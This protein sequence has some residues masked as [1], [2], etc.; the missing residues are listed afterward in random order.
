MIN[1]P[2]ITIDGPSGSG[3]GT[4]AIAV[5]DMLGWHV[6]DSGALY[7]IV[8]YSAL[9]Q[10]LSFDDP[11]K[12]SAMVSDLVIDFK[13]PDPT[14]EIYV[15]GQ[16]VTRDLRTDRVSK[17]ASVAAQYE[18][19]RSSLL[20]LQRKFRRPPG[21]VADGR[22]MGTVVFADAPLKIYLD[23]SVEVRAARRYKQLKEKGLNGTFRGLSDVKLACTK[24]DL[25]GV[26]VSDM[27]MSEIDANQNINL[28]EI[29]VNIAE[30]DEQDKGRQTSPLVRAEDAIYIDSTNLT[31]ENVINEIIKHA[32]LRSLTTVC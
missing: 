2:V 6:L 20:A 16:I 8:A 11:E 32:R 17:A 7:R 12:L 19:V 28:Q 3:K 14:L 4:V 27:N 24:H 29:R 10:G 13:H 30:R 22:D 1:N 15:D 26:P 31:V 21:L 25:R 5:A 9:R 23:A 18:A